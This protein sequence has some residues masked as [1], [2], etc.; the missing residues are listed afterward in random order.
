VSTKRL[1]AAICDDVTWNP[2]IGPVQKVFPIDF[3]FVDK[4]SGKEYRLPKEYAR[5]AIGE[6]S[7][8]LQARIER[9]YKG[10]ADIMIGEFLETAIRRV[11]DYVQR[12]K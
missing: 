3:R 4:S 11:T 6:V 7:E 1:T 9:D 10:A 5:F 8:P 2:N 12:G